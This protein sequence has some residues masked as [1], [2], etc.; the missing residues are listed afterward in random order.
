MMF[1]KYMILTHNDELDLHQYGG[2]WILEFSILNRGRIEG[3]KKCV[4]NWG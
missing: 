1:L 3:I 2:V 4:R